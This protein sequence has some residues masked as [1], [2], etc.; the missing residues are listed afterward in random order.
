MVYYGIYFAL[1]C[2]YRAVTLI[3]GTISNK[4]IHEQYFRL[5][6]I[7]LEHGKRLGF[8]VNNTTIFIE[9]CILIN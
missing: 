7:L 4:N 6:D 1:H 8:D 5:E 2:S 3:E 9:K